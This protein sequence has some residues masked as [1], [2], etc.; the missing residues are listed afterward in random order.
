MNVNYVHIYGPGNKS[1]ILSFKIKFIP[2]ISL[3]KTNIKN[4]LIERIGRLFD[5]DLVV[6]KCHFG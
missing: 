4:S 2:V 6:R 1:M 3:G 5:P